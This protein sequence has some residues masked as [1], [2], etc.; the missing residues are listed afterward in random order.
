M[1]LFCEYFEH[2][3]TVFIR[4]SPRLLRETRCCVVSLQLI[5]TMHYHVPTAME[6]K[7]TLAKHV[8]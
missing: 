8:C 4:L 5:I 6:F 1:K 7:V 2:T 3:C